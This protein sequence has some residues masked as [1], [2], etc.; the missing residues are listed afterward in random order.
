MKYLGKITDDKDLVTKEYVDNSIPV[1]SNFMVKG[2]DRVTA[3]LKSGTT[4]GQYSTAEG[5]SNTASGH[6]SHAEGVNTSATA[7]QAHAEGSGTTAAGNASHAEGAGTTA[8]G[9]YSHT[10]GHGTTAQRLGQHVFGEYNVVETGLNTT[11]G[12]YVEIVGN[13]TADNA[14]SNARTLDWNGN[15]VLAGKLTVGTAPTNDMDVATKKFVDDSIS[16]IDADKTY[17]GGISSSTNLNS[18][19]NGIWDF[20]TTNADFPNSTDTFYGYLI[21]YNTNY[22]TQLLVA[23]KASVC[24][25]YYRRYLQASSSWTAWKKV[26]SESDLSDYMKKGVD[27]VTAGQL[28]GTTLGTNATA[29]GL[30]TTASGSFAHAEGY[31]STA[32]GNSAHAEGRSTAS[33]PCAHAEGQNSNASGEYAHA[34]GD[35]TTASGTSSHAEGTVTMASGDNSHAEGLYTTAQRRSQHV[36]G[37]YNVL[38]TTGSTSTRGAYVEV[39]GNGTSSTR[40]NAR[41]LDWSGN[42]K[43]AGSITIGNSATMRYNSTDKSIDF[44]FI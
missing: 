5:V 22:K 29:E 43:L 40:S 2:V 7:P 28:S 37:E 30:N 19:A 36:F 44:V 18:L 23:G 10:E 4:L 41:T 1:T 11:R 27:Y 16:A 39:V 12:N 25:V 24:D 42:E 14:R 34:E 17:R 6:I 31:S 33:G 3:G 26:A 13:G 35:N 15:E 8:N 21:Q 20:A 9:Y 32:S 38:D